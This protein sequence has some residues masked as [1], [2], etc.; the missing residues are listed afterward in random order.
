MAWQLAPNVTFCIASG[1]VLFLDVGRD[2]YFALPDTL[3]PA[4]LT[5]LE[6]AEVSDDSKGA[7]ALLRAASIVRRVAQATSLE[8][9][10]ISV[11]GRTLDE[12]ARSSIGAR[13]LAIWSRTRASYRRTR[14]HLRQGGLIGLIEAARTSRPASDDVRDPAAAAREFQRA[15]GPRALEGDCLV[16]SFAMLDFLH[17]Q[18][19]DARAVF[20]VMVKPF[21]AHC[22]V[23]SETEILNDEVDHVR[24]FTP[25][26]VI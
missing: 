2:R 16:S 3:S 18:G 25:I 26:L 17:R 5:W 23:Q 10:R 13:S 11:P 22:W 15:R 12:A 14:R 7:I 19:S 4:F 8:P 6:T 24:I 9:V 1:T 21:H 20:G